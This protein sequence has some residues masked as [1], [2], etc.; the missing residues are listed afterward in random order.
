MI[1]VEEFGRMIIKLLGVSSGRRTFYRITV[2]YIVCYI[3]KAR[4][5]LWSR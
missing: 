4:I 1:Y 2:R 5:G 3:Y